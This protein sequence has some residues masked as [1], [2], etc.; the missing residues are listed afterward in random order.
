MKTELNDG[1]R[2]QDGA[3]TY[4]DNFIPDLPWLDVGYENT[5]ICPLC[6][7]SCDGNSG[8]YNHAILVAA[9]IDS[10]EHREEAIPRG[11]SL[12]CKGEN[13]EPR[14]AVRIDFGGECGHHWSLI[15]QQRKGNTIV[16]WR[17]AEEVWCV[18]KESTLPPVWEP[19][20]Y[21]YDN[22]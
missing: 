21:E 22:D 12:C 15:F 19:S 13:G 7:A 3:V 17:K 6:R 14:P 2:S 9:E 5:L 4:Q 8:S 18:L 11:L 16:S 10:D 1:R 20:Q